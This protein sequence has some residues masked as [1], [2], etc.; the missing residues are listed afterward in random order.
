MEQIFKSY[1]SDK[2]VAEMIQGN[3]W[4]LRLQWVTKGPKC[5]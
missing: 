5:M 3:A 1:N 4:G 2:K